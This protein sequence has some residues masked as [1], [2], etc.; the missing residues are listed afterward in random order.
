M[1]HR[2][3]KKQQGTILL[4]TLLFLFILTWI[5]ARDANDAILESKMQNNMTNYA[6][7]FRRAEEGMQKMVLTQEGKKINLPSSSIALSLS[8][9]VIST[10]T[11]GNATIH[12]QSIAKNNGTTVVLNSLNIF[13]K[14]PRQKGCKKIP[15][16]HI[17][18]W[19][20]DT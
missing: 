8:S 16:H 9:T 3:R 1:N 20:D 12:I 19:K 13:A 18:Y 11:C 2:A 5:V 10:D 17:I 4:M 6:A 15:E 7:V 14:V